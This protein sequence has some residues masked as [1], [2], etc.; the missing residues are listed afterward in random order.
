LIIFPLS[1]PVPLPAAGL[2]KHPATTYL[3]PV[4]ALF[5]GVGTLGLEHHID[6]PVGLV[7]EDVVS[8]RGLFQGQVMG[9]EA[10]HPEIR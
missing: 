2:V 8:G 1:R 3:T 10:G 7:T 4:A 6:A 9:G 5:R